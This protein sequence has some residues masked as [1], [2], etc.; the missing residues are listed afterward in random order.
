MKYKSQILT[1]LKRSQSEITKV[2]GIYE[3]TSSYFLVT[4]KIQKILGLMHT[5]DNLLIKHHLHECVSDLM[6][7]KKVDEGIKQMILSYKY[8]H[9]G[10]I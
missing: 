5:A 8:M 9:K 4:N 10:D 2:I 3:Q 1:L 7:Q 6:T